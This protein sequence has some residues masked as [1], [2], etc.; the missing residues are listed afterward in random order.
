M[1]SASC[2]VSRSCTWRRRAKQWT[3]RR[4]LRQ[5]DDASVLGDVG[6]TGFAIEGQHVVFTET[7]VGHL[8]TTIIWS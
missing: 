1:A 8:A 5:A 4:E 3:R 2:S 7:I 6:Q